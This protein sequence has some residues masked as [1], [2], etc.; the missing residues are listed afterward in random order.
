MP[1]AA[2]AETNRP[3]LPGPE[4]PEEEETAAQVQARPQ[5]GLTGPAEAEAALGDQGVLLGTAETES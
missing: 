1:E 3:V 4:V 5:M 2:E